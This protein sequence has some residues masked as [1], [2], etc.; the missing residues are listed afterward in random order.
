MFMKVVAVCAK[1]PARHLLLRLSRPVAVLKEAP[2]TKLEVVMTPCTSRA[3]EQQSRGI[4]GERKA[5]DS[6]A[7]PC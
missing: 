2:Q 6:N 5:S 4:I 7:V 1:L 3:R